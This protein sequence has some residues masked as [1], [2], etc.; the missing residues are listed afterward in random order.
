[1]LIIVY[2]V[3]LMSIKNTKTIK[4]PVFTKAKTIAKPGVSSKDKPNAKSSVQLIRTTVSMDK[5]MH[6]KT[7]Q[8]ASK[9]NL[10]I[11]TAIKRYINK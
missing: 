7:K 1:M 9:N 11:N 8:F 6:G 2:E 10:S 5:I 3:Y 4:K